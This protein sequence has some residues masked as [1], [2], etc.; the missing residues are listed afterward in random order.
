MK[1][2]DEAIG[3]SK[4]RRPADEIGS[5]AEKKPLNS[6]NNDSSSSIVIVEIN[7][8]P[9]KKV[10]CKDE[11]ENRDTQKEYDK[12]YPGV[13]HNQYS[14]SNGTNSIAID[15]TAT[16]IVSE[17]ENNGFENKQTP[18]NNDS[19]ETKVV[20]S[21]GDQGDNSDEINIESMPSVDVTSLEPTGIVDNEAG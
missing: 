2:P 7:S 5:E 11:P 12:I 4:N 15:N 1:Y 9:N 6:S 16:V 14:D 21:P 3:F 10:N 13:R 8:D 20:V 19:S 18:K 17:G